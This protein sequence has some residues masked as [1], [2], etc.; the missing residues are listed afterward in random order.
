[1]I[2]IL[3]TKHFVD[4]GAGMPDFA[5]WLYATVQFALV[6]YVVLII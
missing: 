5:V 2:K 6:L 1:M 4:R 3:S